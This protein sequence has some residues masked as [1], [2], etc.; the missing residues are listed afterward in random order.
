MWKKNFYYLFKWYLEFFI[1]ELIIKEFIILFYILGCLV[2][3]VV[4]DFWFILK[5]KLDNL[6]LFDKYVENDFYL[7]CGILESFLRD[8]LWLEIFEEKNINK[9][10]FFN[11]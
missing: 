8:F 2:G 7:V 4:C 1:F 11:F 10:N 9:K 5:N 6:I 3:L